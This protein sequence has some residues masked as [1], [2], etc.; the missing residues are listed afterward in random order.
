LYKRKKIPREKLLLETDA[1]YLTPTPHR[2]KRNEPAYTAL[3][4]DKVAELSS[5]SSKDIAE[6]STANAQ[7]LFAF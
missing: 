7:R 1:P 6:I 3:V 2:G 4:A 5:Q